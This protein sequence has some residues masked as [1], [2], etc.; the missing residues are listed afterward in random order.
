MIFFVCRLVLFCGMSILATSIG[1]ANEVMEGFPPTSDSQVTK[2]NYLAPPF[3]RWAF[4]NAGAPLNTLMV[5]RGGTVHIFQRDENR[6]DGYETSKGGCAHQGEPYQ[7]ME[8]DSRRMQNRRRR[9]QRQSNPCFL[10][11]FV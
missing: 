1:F 5:P 2:A 8:Q 9:T 11:I 7:P 6:L 3:N 10:V 4:R